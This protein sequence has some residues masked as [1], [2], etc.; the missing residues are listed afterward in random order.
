MAAWDIVVIGAGAAGMAAA[1]SAAATGA[2]TLLVDRMG[3]GGELMNLGEL[4]D[5]AEA[6]GQPGPEFAAAL[7]DAAMA[8]GAELAIG[9]VSALSGPPWVVTVDGE[10]HEAAAVILATGLH[11][12]VLGVDGEEG[13]EGQGLSH[14]A[15]CDG[16][17]Y[18]GQPVV[19]AGHDRWAQQEARDLVA[20]AGSVTLVTQGA[21]V[22]PIAGVTIIA[23]AVEALEGAAGL[24]AVQAAGQRIP[25]RAIFVQCNRRAALD[26]APALQADEAGRAAVDAAL[27]T[28]QPGLYAVGDVRAGGEATLAAALADGRA[29]A[30]A[31]LRGLGKAAE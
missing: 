10:A 27:H 30:A 15:A 7:L 5:C 17:L 31:A 19:V 29:A 22:P 4:H 28:S 11:H 24:D 3:C 25:A 9:E 2:A 1:T 18:K 26:F 16:P 12:G 6:E 14:C 13:F 21:A 8:A 23:G 20:T